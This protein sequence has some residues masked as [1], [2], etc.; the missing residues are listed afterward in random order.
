MWRLTAGEYV[1]RIASMD[2]RWESICSVVHEIDDNGAAFSATVVVEGE[3]SKVVHWVC[4]TANG[5]HSAIESFPEDQLDRA[6]ARYEELQR[7]RP[8]TPPGQGSASGRR[9]GGSWPTR[10]ATGIPVQQPR[11]KSPP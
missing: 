3:P 4:R 9:S 2:G 10:R 11:R 6:L 1:E 7:G 5:R 8:E